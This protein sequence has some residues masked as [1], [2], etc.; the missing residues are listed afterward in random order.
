MPSTSIDVLHVDDD[1]D[2]TEVAAIYLQRESDRITVQ[3]A[4][5]ASE[6]LDAV[7]RNEFD[8][9]ISDYNMP[10]QNGLEFLE[11]VRKAEC[12][13]PFILY[14]GK[15]SE[16]VASDAIAAGVTDYLRKRAGTEQYELLANRI[17]N[18]VEQR[19]STQRAAD[20]ERVRQ[21]I[22]KADQAL[23]RA[24][25]RDE[26]EQRICQIV[27]D[28]DPYRFAWISE[29]DP[30][31]R[32]VSAN[33]ASGVGESYLEAIEITTDEGPTGQGPTGKALRNRELSVVQNI[34]EDAA[35]EPWRE[36]ALD[37]GYQSSA[38]IP[39]VQGDADTLYGVLNVYADRIDAFD[40]EEQALLQEL[41]DDTAHALFRIEE[42]DRERELERTR[43][44]ID[45]SLDALQDV[46]FVLDEE[47]ELIRWNSRV[48]AV[49][50]YTDE[51]LGDMAAT[52]FFPEKHHERIL[53]TAN[54]VLE[55]GSATVQADFLTR[56]GESIPYEFRGT[57]ST[58]PQ[59]DGMVIVG[60]GRDVTEQ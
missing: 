3:T 48:S 55:T 58:D 37:R 15:G 8:C 10:G 21:V 47:M 51:E 28:A 22:R 24:E 9:I 34:P 17:T 29:P 13:L 60:I 4:T 23:V 49:T 44:F 7:A 20:L 40:D 38:A 26:I 1:P 35:Y 52:A 16:E 46:F 39:V 2:L 59:G 57:R 14:T 54:E 12:D 30:E 19:R 56:D 41:A 42:R 11:A 27:T 18:A 33:T 6:G 32:I 31:S 5:S 50:G 43:L 53:N 25:T 36:E 45:E